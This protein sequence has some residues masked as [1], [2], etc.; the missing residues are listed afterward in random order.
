[1]E[2]IK[3]NLQIIKLLKKIPKFPIEVKFSATDDGYYHKALIIKNGEI[4]ETNCLFSNR[5][6]FFYP[7]DY[8]NSFKET[9][10][11]V[12]HY[13]KGEKGFRKSCYNTMQ[14]IATY[15]YSKLPTIYNLLCEGSMKNFC[16]LLQ[17]KHLK[18]PRKF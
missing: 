16:K 1:M 12:Y 14:F 13:K 8:P 4:V 9:I 18:D 7:D 5:C 17:M 2:I 10:E 15:N 3:E 11:L 6:S